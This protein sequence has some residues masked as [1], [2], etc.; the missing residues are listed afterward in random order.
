M[1]AP[2]YFKY[3]PTIARLFTPL[4][5]ILMP[6]CKLL[7]IGGLF[8]KNS[9]SERIMRSLVNSPFRRFNVKILELNV[10]WTPEEYDPKLYPLVFSRLPRGAGLN[11]IWHY[12]QLVNNGGDHFRKFDYGITEN[13]KRYKSVTPPEYPLENMEIP[14]YFITSKDDHLCDVKDNDLLWSKLQNS[15]KIYGRKITSGLNHADFFFGK[16]PEVIDRHLGEGNYE[17]YTVTTKDGY[18][19]T[20]FRI[21][22]KNP[23]GVIMLQHPITGDGVIWVSQGNRSL[24]NIFSFEEIGLYDYPAFAEKISEVSNNTKIIFIGQSMACTSSIIYASVMPEHVKKYFKVFI[25]MATPVYFKHLTTVAKYLAPLEHIIRPLFK[26]L[27]IG[28]FFYKNSITEEL[29]RSIVYFPFKRFIVILISI[30]AGWTPH[31]YN[32]TMFPLVFS[33]VP[34]G[35]GLS[36]VWHY[37]QLVN[38]GGE[39]FRRFDYGITEN[40]IRYKSATPPEY[41]LENME[42][43][44]YFITSKNDAFCNSKNNDLLWRGLDNNVCTDW[45]SY[46][47]KPISPNCYHDPDVFANTPE[48]IDRH[49]GEGNY[50]NYTVTTKDGYIL[51]LFRIVRKNPKGV[52]MLQHPIMAD[53]VVWVSPGNRSLAFI[54]WELGYEVWLPNHRG[55]YFSEKHVN[56]TVH[57]FKYWSFSF[58]EIGLYDYPAFAE[59]ISEVSNNTKLIFI[60]HSMS[61][62]SSIIYASV[63]PKH[64]KKY[65]KVFIQMASPPLFKTLGIGGFFTK[66]SIT[67]LIAKSIVYFPFKRFIVILLSIADGWTPYEFNPTMFPL[68]LSRSPRGSGLNVVWH[69]AQL[70]NNGGEYFRRFDYGIAENLIRYKSATPPEYPLENMEIPNYFITSKNDA[71]CNPKDNDLL[72]SKL[73]TSTK[74]YGR[75]ITRGLNH[76]DFHVGKH[77]YENAYKYIIKLLNKL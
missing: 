58:E 32:P 68:F 20:L 41:P 59:K 9:I 71:F 33:R 36:V 77:V 25:Q 63:M 10:G 60:G 21:I 69:Y 49:L 43:P 45:N 75:K 6:L 53:G 7:G 73:Q 31:E 27:G 35:S 47:T 1:A 54:L 11:V 8:Y 37:A 66:N 74:I 51:T 15:T 13:F 5:P 50:E 48:V 52:I 67:E 42:I 18:I 61:C 29:A 16:H 56:L 39:Y 55:T 28:G 26:T 30:V 76:V 22:R 38:N 57:D 14:N 2:V 70:V 40:L 3:V 24:G 12:L 44:N 19:L 23:K 72:W 4:E 64:V 17:N 34:R 46:Y 62:T 65:F